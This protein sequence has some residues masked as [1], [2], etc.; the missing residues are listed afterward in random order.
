MNSEEWQITRKIRDWN[1][2]VMSWGILASS[3]DGPV[4]RGFSPRAEHASPQPSTIEL[5]LS[6]V[7]SLSDFPGGSVVKN[8]P[9]DAADTGSIPDP[10]RF[11]HS[12]EQL[13]L[14]ACALLSLCSRAQKPQLLS[15]RALKPMLRNQRSHCNKKLL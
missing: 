5:Y 2:E 13:S 12:S 15:S 4:E 7:L 9:V 6:Q 14:G 1:C 10:G 8:V 11:P 3:Q